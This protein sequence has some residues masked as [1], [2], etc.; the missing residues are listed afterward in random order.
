[1]NWPPRCTDLNPIEH[2][3]DISEKGVKAHHTRPVVIPEVC[4]ALANVWQVIPMEFFHKLV[5]SMP[6]CV[7]AIIHAKGNQTHY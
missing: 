1:M 7:A 6:C 3:W 5:E 2:L 4:I